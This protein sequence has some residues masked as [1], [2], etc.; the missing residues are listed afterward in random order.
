[1]A[2]TILDFLHIPPPASFAGVSLLPGHGERADIR[3]ERL[4]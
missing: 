2:P 4:S 3:R 1:M